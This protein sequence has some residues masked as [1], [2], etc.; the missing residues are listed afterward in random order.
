MPGATMLLISATAYAGP[1][2]IAVNFTG[3]L[4]ASQQALFSTAANT[5]MGLLPSY[6]SGINIASLAINASGVAID[7]VGGI[8]G[9]AG[10]NTYV[11]QAGYRVAN[12]GTMQFD[13][14]DLANMESNGTLLAVI[15]HEMA[16]VMGFGTLWSLNS[17][18]SGGSGQFTGANAIAAYITEFNQ[19][20]AT[21]VPVE[22]GGS[23]GTANGH[24]NEMDG[25]WSDLGIASA[26]GDM[27]FE[28]MTGWVSAPYYI[29][30][31]TVASFVDIGYV[32]AETGVPEPATLLLISG[33]L[34][35]I[36][37]RRY[38]RN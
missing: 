33:G 27:R 12:S 30:N 4:T 23:P 26:Q 28:V 14:E 36:G 34:A 24:W 29:S 13:S 1:F 22:L 11:N 35:L 15:L 25:G 16:H 21:F 2:T 7:G 9:S 10:P 32:S 8:L 31:T 38:R 18:Y 20:S 6:Q 17:V 3:G 37:F 19:P 5:W